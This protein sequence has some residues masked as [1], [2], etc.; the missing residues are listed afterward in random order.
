MAHSASSTGRPTEITIVQ[1]SN[2]S[3]NGIHGLDFLVGRKR[4]ENAAKK[5]LT[6]RI[7][8][9]TGTRGIARHQR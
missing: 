7:G 5:L 2:T 1:D 3:K 8:K 6:R 9:G 4:L